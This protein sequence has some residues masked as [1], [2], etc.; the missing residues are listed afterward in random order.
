MKIIH[1]ALLLSLTCSVGSTAIAAGRND[2][3]ATRSVTDEAVIGQAIEAVNNP[4]NILF[5]LNDELKKEYPARKKSV[6]SGEVEKLVDTDTH[7]FARNLG[8]VAHAFHS[9]LSLETIKEDL[10]GF[11][12]YSTQWMAIRIVNHGE[13]SAV[14]V[15][16]TTISR[17]KDSLDGLKDEDALNAIP[18]IKEAEEVANEAV[19][20][21][22][23]EVEVVLIKTAS[24]DK[25]AV[26][27]LT[28]D[29]DVALKA[30]IESLGLTRFETIYSASSVKLGFDTQPVTTERSLFYAELVNE[31]LPAGAKGIAYPQ[32]CTWTSGKML[33]R[34]AHANATDALK[35]IFTGFIKSGLEANMNPKAS[36]K[37]DFDPTAGRTW[38]LDFVSYNL[39]RGEMNIEIYDT[40]AEL[41]DGGYAGA[42]KGGE[43]TAKP[44]SS[45]AIRQAL[46]DGTWMEVLAKDFGETVDQNRE[47]QMY[48]AKARN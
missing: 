9:G 14:L 17:S 25:A 19:Y 46:V 3:L 39:A 44:W 30:E 11:G 23:E 20:Y 45:G 28:L 35:S 32:G 42:V 13:Y 7:I 24:L 16:K 41:L 4:S 2:S 48:E 15:S 38:K 33:L 31:T 10:S 18:A 5:N 27:G 21:S 8:L 26:I 47:V 43:C 40:F 34:P 36:G 1:A 29:S 22:G 37:L 12:G 6:E